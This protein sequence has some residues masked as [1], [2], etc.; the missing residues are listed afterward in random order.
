MVDR[1][2]SIGED[3]IISEKDFSGEEWFASGHFPGASIFPGAMMQEMSTQSGGILI[4]ARYNPMSEF[5]TRDPYFNRYALGVLVR[6]KRAKYIGFARPGDTLRA[7]VRLNEIVGAMFDFSATIR[8][9]DRVIMRN[10]FQLS[11]IASS[12][13]QGETLESGTA[14]GN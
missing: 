1:I 11:N 4:A 8:V 10:A 13:L 9:D 6:V 2:D 12:L 14:G 3:A 5:D 7:E